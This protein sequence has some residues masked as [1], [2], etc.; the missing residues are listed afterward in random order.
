[1]S[2]AL[3]VFTAVM[4]I[5]TV[6]IWEQDLHLTLIICSM[7]AAA[8]GILY[9]KFS[10]AEIEKGMIDGIYT[11]LQA[12]LILYTVGP[13]V[14]SWIASGV[15]PSMIYY[16]LNILN[17]TI[18]LFATLLICS[19]VAIAT[20]TSWGT[21]GTVGIALMGIAV[22]LG[23]PAPMT[24]GIIISG[25][26]FGDKMS[27]LSDTTNLAP[28][29]AGTDLFQHIRAMCWTSAPTY[30]IVGVI[31]LILGFK[32]AGG[33]LDTAKINAMQQILSAEFWISPITFIARV[34]QGFAA[35]RSSLQGCGEDE[36]IL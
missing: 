10:Y 7:V 26:Y 6:R 33:S 14:G 28:A 27:P 11:A 31:T 25:A 1:M 19:I 21:T 5:S 36:I 8:V 2:I 23:I 15:V 34:Y 29:V 24:A 3:F 4:I 20:G 13:L 22:G 18:F 35:Y 30:C 17:P 16:G 9:L 12:M 32:Y